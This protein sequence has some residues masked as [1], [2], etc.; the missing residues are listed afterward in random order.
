MFTFSSKFVSLACT[1]PYIYLFHVSAFSRPRHA[2]A[3]AS[4]IKRLPVELITEIFES[5]D[6]IADVTHLARISRFFADTWKLHAV[7]ICG[8]ILPRIILSY[9]T[10][11]E[12][13]VAV[14]RQK[15]RSEGS[16]R[17]FEDSP[18]N[19]AKM[20][21]W[22]SRAAALQ[23]LR[24]ES[25]YTRVLFGYACSC[26]PGLPET[27]N[28]LGP[29]AP[30]L[31]AHE[32]NQFLDF[33]YELW[34]LTTMPRA[35]AKAILESMPPSQL[36]PLQRFGDFRIIQPSGLRRISLLHLED[37]QEYW[38]K[39]LDVLSQCFEMHFRRAVL[40]PPR[41]WPTILGSC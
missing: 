10:V 9:E 4:P 16:G 7:T 29:N 32:R 34:M 37:R 35:S 28:D 30:K 36:G 13:A 3:N 1:P 24:Y 31:C 27:Y 15:I 20:I 14:I 26:N 23:T 38:I 39:S 19:K 21:V 17:I 40:P 33:Y 2:M 12:L 11:S 25:T 6:S 18:I 5:F 22:L 8:A 41:C